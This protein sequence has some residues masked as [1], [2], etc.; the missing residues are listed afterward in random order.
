MHAGGTRLTF[1]DVTATCRFIAGAPKNMAC[2][3]AE[4]MGG[5][6]V[7]VPF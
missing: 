1:L 5:S 3:V 2:A 4:C 7:G 6:F